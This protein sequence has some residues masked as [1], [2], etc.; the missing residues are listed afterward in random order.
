MSYVVATFLVLTL[1]GS[2]ALETAAAKLT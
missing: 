2:V 1:A